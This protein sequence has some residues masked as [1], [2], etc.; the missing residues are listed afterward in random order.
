MVG[1]VDQSA[2]LVAL[3][4]LVDPAAAHAE[5]APPMPGWHAYQ[6]RVPR[7]RAAYQLGERVC[8][9]TPSG[10]RVAECRMSQNV[11]SWAIQSESCDVSAGLPAPSTAAAS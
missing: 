1:P 8:L 7:E 10:R 2:P 3:A 6:V 5:P 9:K 4:V 11:T